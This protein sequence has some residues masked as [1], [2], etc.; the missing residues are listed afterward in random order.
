M[1]LMLIRTFSPLTAPRSYTETDLPRADQY[2]FAGGLE[3]AQ[4]QRTHEAA[5]NVLHFLG[6]MRIVPGPA[7]RIVEPP[8]QINDVDVHV[9]DGLNGVEAFAGLACVVMAEQLARMELGDEEGDG[10]GAIFDLVLRV[11]LV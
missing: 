4:Y 8:D 10:H 9:V 3:L 6:L 7:D 11:V 5:T 2:A 1:E